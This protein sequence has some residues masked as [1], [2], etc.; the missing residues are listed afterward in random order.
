MSTRKWVPFQTFRL[1]WFFAY[2]KVIAKASEDALVKKVHTEL[3]TLA[4][5]AL[6]AIRSGTQNSF[7]NKLE[8][9]RTRDFGSELE[10]MLDGK[11]DDIPSWLRK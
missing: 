7:L 9:I 2:N 10:H 4:K 3:A 11:G 6:L 1:E 8:A 5:K